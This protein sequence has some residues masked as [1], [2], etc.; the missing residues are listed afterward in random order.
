MAYE[1]YFEPNGA[2]WRIRIITY[3]L[4]FFTRSVVI[5][6]GKWPDKDTDGVLDFSTY[7][8]AVAYAES[9][10]LPKAYQRRDRHHGFVTQANTVFAHAANP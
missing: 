6:K 4:V 2:V 1:I 8:E 3:W 5:R 7:D 9:V 10:G